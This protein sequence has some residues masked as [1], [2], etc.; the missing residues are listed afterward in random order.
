L[1]GGAD[2]TP[3]NRAVT[4]ARRTPAG[5]GD[6]N[7]EKITMRKLTLLAASVVTLAIFG[8]SSNPPP[9]PAAPPNVTVVAPPAPAAPQPPPTVNVTP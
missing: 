6:Q 9:A 5:I 1:H 4:R 2:I 3:S 7:K 8:C